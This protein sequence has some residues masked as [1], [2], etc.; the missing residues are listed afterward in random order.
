MAG[1]TAKHL[2]QNL[3]LSTAYGGEVSQARNKGACILLR[4]AFLDDT[5]ARA[6][7]CVSLQVSVSRNHALIFQARAAILNSKHPAD[8]QHSLFFVHTMPR[9][10]RKTIGNS[11]ARLTPAARNRIIGMALASAPKSEMRDKVRKTD[12]L[13]PSLRAIDDLLTIVRDDPEWVS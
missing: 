6:V 3:K 7:R 4:P 10:V 1:R 5:G 11:F 12:G 13:P 8:R 9:G 2:H